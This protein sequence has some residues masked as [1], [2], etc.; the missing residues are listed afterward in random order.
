MDG[1]SPAGPSPGCSTERLARFTSTSRE[2]WASVDL[3]AL[4]FDAFRHVV[5]L[6]TEG[7]AP[8]QCFVVSPDGGGQCWRCHWL[9]IEDTATLTASQQPWLDV[10]RD[11]LRETRHPHARRRPVVD[12]DAESDLT[13]EIFW[14]PPWSGTRALVSWLDTARAPAEALIQ[15]AE[16]VAFTTDGHIVAVATSDEQLWELPGGRREPGESIDDA[17][18]REVREEA[19]A[20]VV[21]SELVGF[22]RFRHLS[23]ERVGQVA[24]DA[25]FWA[26]VD[27]EPFEPRFE[28]RAR[29]L[30]SLAAARGLP[31]WANPLTQRLLSRAADAEH[32]QMTRI[33]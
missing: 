11:H 32:R 16:A 4:S 10:A 18:R 31:L 2:R 28:T 5:H 8:D 20:R 21:A 24:T 26:R 19:C 3:E 30:L 6:T 23:G 27:L 9:S 29:L 12:A 25:L 15:R 17:L 14:A 13:I 1:S 33:D 7:A 22:Q